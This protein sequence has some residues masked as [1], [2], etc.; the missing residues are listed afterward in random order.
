MSIWGKGGEGGTKGRS[1]PEAGDLVQIR[2][3]WC[4]LTESNTI[5]CRL[6][7]R[8][9]GLTQVNLLQLDPTHDSINTIKALTATYA[10]LIWLTENCTALS[11]R[12]NMIYSWLC[13]YNEP[14]STVDHVVTYL[15]HDH[16]PDGDWYPSILSCKL[17]AVTLRIALNL[18]SK[19][20]LERGT[21]LINRNTRAC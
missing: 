6:S 5:F 15:F 13:E 19:L 10:S 20:T 1:P 11:I 3:Q 2:L 16:S 9:G 14:Q 21:N 8:D 12:Y 4:T 18:K 17:L 7:I